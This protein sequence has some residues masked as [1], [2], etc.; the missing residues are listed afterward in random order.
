M[1][2]LADTHALLW[3]LSGDAR[4]SATARRTYEDCD[5]LYFS[6]VSLWEIG[7][8]LALDRR[9]FRLAPSWWRDIPQQLSAEGARRLE[10]TAEHC[11]EVAKLPMH[12]RDPFDRMLLAQ[13]LQ[14]S[15]AILS[16]NR[17]FD[18][19]GVRRVW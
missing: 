9:D 4:L 7:I 2:L 8:K 13:A 12:H 17:Q 5:E 3:A 16:A 18:A 19:Y 14:E 1:K 6:V 11:R 10:V 15:C